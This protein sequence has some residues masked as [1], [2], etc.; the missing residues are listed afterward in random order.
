[1]AGTRLL[2]GSLGTYVRR[3]I[4]KFYSAMRKFL[5]CG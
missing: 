2:D 4:S 3:S 5:R 1:M